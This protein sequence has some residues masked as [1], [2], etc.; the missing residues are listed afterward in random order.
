MEQKQILSELPAGEKSTFC[1]AAGVQFFMF[2][3]GPF[4][5]CAGYPGMEQPEN[6]SLELYQ[7]FD[8]PFELMELMHVSTFEQLLEMVP[9]DLLPLYERE[10]INIV[11]TLEGTMPRE[12]SFR[13]YNGDIWARNTNEEIH[14]VNMQLERPEDFIAYTLR[15]YGVNGN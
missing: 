4:F 15:Y 10:V 9:A 13:K 14:K 7:Q 5:I 2:A 6:I 1:N 8:T 3:A 11:C 12:M